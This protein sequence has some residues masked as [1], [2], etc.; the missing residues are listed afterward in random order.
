MKAT[1]IAA[2]LQWGGNG[3]LRRDVAGVDVESRRAIGVA[4]PARA[5][6][7]GEASWFARL[8]LSR[9]ERTRP[10]YFAVLPR[11]VREPLASVPRRMVRAPFFGLRQ[12]CERVRAELERSEAARPGR[13][14]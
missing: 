6:S 12:R 5:Q 14:R 3:I 10:T 9:C 4:Y 13:R 2:T 11:C 8:W 1:G 7:T